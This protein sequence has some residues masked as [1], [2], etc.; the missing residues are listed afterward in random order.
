VAILGRERIN[1]R[2]WDQPQGSSNRPTLNH[3]DNHL[4]RNWDKRR[5]WSGATELI[6]VVTSVIVAEH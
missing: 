2:R 6:E 1:V 5:E 4:I 3:P